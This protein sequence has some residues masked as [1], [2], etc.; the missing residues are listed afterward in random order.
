MKNEELLISKFQHIFIMLH[1]AIMMNDIKRVKHFLSDELFQKYSLFLQNLTVQHERQMYDELN[2]KSSRILQVETT[3]NEK[4]ITVEIISRYMD[5]IVDKDT[6]Q[7]KR[8]VNTHRVEKRNILVFEKKLGIEENSN[9]VSCCNCGAPLDIHYTG[10]CSY[11]KETTSRKNCD[12][13]LVSLKTD[14]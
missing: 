8:G 10:V 6:M 9:T 3:S 7:Y 11:C 14:I 5:Y 1:H 13:I 2:V 12:Y 4:R